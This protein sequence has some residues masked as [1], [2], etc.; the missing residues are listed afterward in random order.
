MDDS[1]LANHSKWMG[2]L[3]GK[4]MSL[5][6][7]WG[8]LHGIHALRRLRACHPPD[9]T[10]PDATGPRAI[11]TGAI[12]PLPCPSPRPAL[13]FGKFLVQDGP[14]LSFSFRLASCLQSY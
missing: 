4:P 7:A 8:I 13:L 3:G 11:R 5:R 14:R 1:Q 10:R 2:L 9:V 6:R 12:R